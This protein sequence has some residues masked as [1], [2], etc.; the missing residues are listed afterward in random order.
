MA[1]SSASRCT[2]NLKQITERSHATARHGSG[3]FVPA[4]STIKIQ[5]EP[6]AERMS[7]LQEGGVVGSAGSS[8]TISIAPLST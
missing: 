8:V 3:D 1:F 4:F 7:S 6:T 5:I 2:G